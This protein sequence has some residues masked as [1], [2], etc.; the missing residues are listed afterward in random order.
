MWFKPMYVVIG[1][2]MQIDHKLV[3]SSVWHGKFSNEDWTGCEIDVMLLEKPDYTIVG[4]FDV[5]TL[6]P[7]NK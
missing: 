3:A 6:H 7:V 1:Y 2:A 4:Y 5:K